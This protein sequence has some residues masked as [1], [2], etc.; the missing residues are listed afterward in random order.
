[1]G[2]LVWARWRFELR[3]VRGG[4]GYGG[5]ERLQAGDCV[6]G[7]WVARVTKK[8][9]WWWHWRREDSGA[10]AGGTVVEAVCLDGMGAVG[11]C[12]DG[13]R[14]KILTAAT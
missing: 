7:L 12:T 10:I 9:R 8:K 1:M 14:H 4:G 11:V 3:V 13:A 6:D 5:E 2:G